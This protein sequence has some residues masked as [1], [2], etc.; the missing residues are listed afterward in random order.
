M[1]PWAPG[2]LDHPVVDMTG[3]EGAWDFAIF[4]SAKRFTLGGGRGMGPG[5]LAPVGDSAGLTIFEAVDR[6]M[7][8]KLEPEKHPL[9]VL[10]IDHVEEKPAEN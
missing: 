9:P 4:W 6:Q 10:V 8:L 3:I 1:Q 7:G 5:G 2:Y